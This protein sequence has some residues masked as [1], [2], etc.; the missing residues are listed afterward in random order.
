[1]RA[2][3]ATADSAALVIAAIGMW[4]ANFF[5]V[6]FGWPPFIYCLGQSFLGPVLGPWHEIGVLVMLGWFAIQLG[7]GR[8]YGAFLAFA[9][10]ILVAG[11][12]TFADILFRLGGS[13]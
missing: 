10:V 8:F 7:T 3:P 9:A 11:I 2:K 13:C 5:A 4:S 1:M 6:K 12:P